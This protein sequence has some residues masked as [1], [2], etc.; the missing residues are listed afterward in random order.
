MSYKWGEKTVPHYLRYTVVIL[1]YKSL[2]GV[3]GTIPWASDP[4]EDLY[5][6]KTNTDKE[7]QIKTN[8]GT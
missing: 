3:I 6:H 5:K 2:S 7:R 4:G 1:A 8:N